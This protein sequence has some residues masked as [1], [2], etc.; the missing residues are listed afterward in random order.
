[1]KFLVRR[2]LFLAV[3]SMLV[4]FTS[5]SSAE[6]AIVVNYHLQSD[7]NGGGAVPNSAATN[8]MNSVDAAVS[9]FNIWSDYNKVVN[10]YYNSGIPTAEA[11][12]DGYIGFGAGGQYHTPSVAWHEMLHV[13]GSGTYWN[14]WNFVGGGVWTGENAIAMTEQYYPDST[15]RADGH[16][17]WVEGQNFDLTR[18]GV[19]IIGAMRED[20]G[21]SN[22][23]KYDLLGDFNDSKTINARDYII[24][25]NNYLTDISS[26]LSEV[27]AYQRG[28]MNGDR[29]LDYLDFKAFRQAYIEANGPESFA[30]L[31]SVP[32]PKS[33]ALFLFSL[34][35]LV[36]GA[37][38][39]VREPWQ[40]Q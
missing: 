4:S 8:I 21:I 17:H 5:T 28:D 7:V 25:R 27:E 29:Q 31:L 16:V 1:M 10:V 6:A 26:P 14:Y 30:A 37:R 32:E 3:C 22:G 24:F 18:A 40:L 13:M 23:N 33:L 36:G 20:M 39:I 9:T 2:I 15:L 11:N 19:H 38:E 35:L 34:V 12:F